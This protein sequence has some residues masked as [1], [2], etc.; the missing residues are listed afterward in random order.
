[1]NENKGIAVTLLLLSGPLQIVF[2]IAKNGFVARQESSPRFQ[3]IFY[4]PYFSL[5]VFV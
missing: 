1:M 5:E 4:Q 3:E 2:G